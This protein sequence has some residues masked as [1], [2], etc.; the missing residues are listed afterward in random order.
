M[1]LSRNSITVFHVGVYGVGFVTV[2]PA[3][4]VEVHAVQVGPAVFLGVPAE[5]FCRFGLDMKAK[6]KFPYT[7]PVSFANGCI[8]YVPTEDAF[9]PH[10]GGYETRLTSYSNLEITAGR[11]MVEAAARLAGSMTPGTLPEPPKPG[12]FRGPW[13]YGNVPPEVE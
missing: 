6:S 9:G 2:Q 5:M 11:Q 13:S 3:A 12:A 4:E 8:G 7:F 10:G 1:Y